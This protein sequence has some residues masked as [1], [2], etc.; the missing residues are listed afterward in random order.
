MRA[1]RGDRKW[2]AHKDGRLMFVAADEMTFNYRQLL[3]LMTDDSPF[4]RSG[5]QAIDKPTRSLHSLCES[6][7]QLSQ[8]PVTM[9]QLSFPLQSAKTPFSIRQTFINA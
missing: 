9:D 4:H 5:S 1:L 8:P 3:Q 7:H 6:S 2:P